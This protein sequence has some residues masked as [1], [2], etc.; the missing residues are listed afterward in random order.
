MSEKQK[1]LTLREQ[2]VN[3]VGLALSNY[4]GLSELTTTKEG[5]LFELE[6][7]HFVVKLIQK[8]R[9]VI[10]ADVTGMFVQEVAEQEL[11]GEEEGFESE[12]E[13]TEDLE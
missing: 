11:Q 9:N 6:G 3:H 1:T 4:F 7:K 5:F 8:K 2:A 13:E 12:E 10:Q